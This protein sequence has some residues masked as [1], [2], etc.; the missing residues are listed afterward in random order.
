MRLALV[1]VLAVAL[2]L[3]AVYGIGGFGG[4]ADDTGKCGATL[5]AARALKPLATGDVAAFTPAETRRDLSA[6][7]FDRAGPATT[8]LG[9]WKGRVVL[10]NLWATWCVPC[11]KEMPA[12]DRLQKKLGSPDFEVVALNLD[13]RDP[14]RPKKFLAD[15]AVKDLAW[16]A[17]PTLASMKGLQKLGLVTGLPTTILIDRQGCEL[18]ALAGPAEW[19]GADATALI[20]AALKER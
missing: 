5:A 15:I 19:D 17:D 20:G 16:Y 18:G 7:V 13:T 4:N 10:L 3:G 12:L 2:G 14:E 9:A 6:L 8:T 11:R 1:A